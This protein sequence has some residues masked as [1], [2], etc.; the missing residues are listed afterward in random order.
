MRVHFS[1]TIPKVFV[2]INHLFPNT[3]EN[4]AQAQKYQ[5]YLKLSWQHID[6]LFSIR[7]FGRLYLDHTVSTGWC[8]VWWRYLTWLCAG[9]AATSVRNVSGNN[10]TMSDRNTNVDVI[11]SKGWV[12]DK[13]LCFITGRVQRVEQVHSHVRQ[14][15]VSEQHSWRVTA[16]CCCLLWKHRLN[17]T[18]TLSLESLMADWE[19]TPSMLSDRDTVH[20]CGNISVTV[21]VLKLQKSTEKPEETEAAELHSQSSPF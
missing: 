18:W 10:Q 20:L 5:H 14:Q 12:W 15:W 3:L 13:K 19:F 9:S 17:T 21:S 1:W 2:S 6:Y 16:D 4:E 7:H 11:G 8:K